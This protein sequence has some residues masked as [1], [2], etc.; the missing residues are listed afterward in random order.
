M[1]TWIVNVLIVVAI[2][3]NCLVFFSHHDLTNQYRQVMHKKIYCNRSIQI[4][5]TSGITLIKQLCSQWQQ[6]Y[7]S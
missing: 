5:D 6:E 4:S 3:F 2:D 1:I 7:R